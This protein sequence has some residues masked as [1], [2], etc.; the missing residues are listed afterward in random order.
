MNID[1][2]ELL[3][4]VHARMWAYCNKRV[5]RLLI[6]LIS[7]KE[8]MSMGELSEIYGLGADE[9]PN[10]LS[11][12]MSTG[13]LAEVGAEYR[14]INPKTGES[15]F[16]V[17]LQCPHCKS[18]DLIR[19]EL[20]EHKTC[21]FIGKRSEYGKKGDRLVCPS[22]G[23]PVKGDEL[24]IVGSWY[25]CKSCGQTFPKPNVILIGTESGM[26][27]K[28]DELTPVRAP[29]YALA[30]MIAEEAKLMVSA[31]DA[32]EAK[33]ESHD[34]KP[35][36]DNTVR[37][38]SGAEHEFCMVAKRGN[39]T[40]AVD[41]AVLCG[42]QGLGEALRA[43]TKA[44]DA[45]FSKIEVVLLAVPEPPPPVIQ[46]LSGSSATSGRFHFLYAGSIAELP[47]KLDEVL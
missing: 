18:F 12:L 5:R 30:E 29:S 43:L 47:Q 35:L 11:K 34:Y 17:R 28:V 44:Y 20:V 22:C 33:L 21:G 16:Y 9:L 36:D 3:N 27:V 4:G 39:V 42:E 38:A 32:L 1:E 14:S 19:E 15:S 41:I 45:S 25:M 8:P 2:C 23:N 26:E 46:M 13:L 7:S 6:P 24:L 40:M 31:F 10:M 37:G